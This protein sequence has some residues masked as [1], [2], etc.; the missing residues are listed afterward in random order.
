M[1]YYYQD[2]KLYLHLHLQT[3]SK[4][5]SIGE[6]YGERLRLRIR[7][8]PIEGRANKQLIAFLARE[9]GVSKSKVVI[10][11]GLHGR[12]K[13]V[14]IAYHGKRPAWFLELN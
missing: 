10:L 11:S 7:A 12:D 4:Q 8:Q 9:F 14:S 1:A 13:T 6:L 5:D 3:G 2:G